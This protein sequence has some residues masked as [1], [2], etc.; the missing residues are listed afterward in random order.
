MPKIFPHLCASAQ[1]GREKPLQ[2]DSV[3]KLHFGKS[4]YS[5]WKQFLYRLFNSTEFSTCVEIPV[6]TFAR[7]FHTFFGSPPFS[8]LFSVENPAVYSLYSHFQPIFQHFLDRIPQF[9]VSTGQ[10]E[11]LFTFLQQFPKFSG[12]GSWKF[13]Q[14]ILPDTEQKKTLFR[15]P[16]STNQQPLYLLLNFL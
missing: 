5:F 6:E 11:M 8:T 15:E 2:T 4:E 1:C 3:W 14:Q 13:R 10:C 12:H 16:C 9:Q 7:I